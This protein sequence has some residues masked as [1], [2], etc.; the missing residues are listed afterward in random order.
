MRQGIL[1]WSSKAG[2]RDFFST[3]LRLEATMERKI[4]AIVRQKRNPERVSIFLDEEYAFG[5]TRI[6]AAWLQV[7]QYLSEEKIDSLQAEDAQEVAYLIAIKY[8]DYRERSETEI[9]AHL[10][11]RDINERVIEDV[12]DRLLRSGLVDDRRF[13]ANWVENRLEFRPRGR[14]A[15]SYELR[16][17]GISEEIIRETLD[18]I[19]DEELAYQAAMKKAKNFQSLEWDEFRKKMLGFLSR[20]GFSYNITSTI[21]TRVWDELNEAQFTKNTLTNK[22]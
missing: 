16:Q 9:R 21:L 20:R 18:S 6:V 14:R 19:N 15:L 4:T 12:I 10:N 11:K 17:K 3:R 22:R 7:G 13:A 8:L 5:L 2:P 1:P